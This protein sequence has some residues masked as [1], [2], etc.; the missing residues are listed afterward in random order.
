M[1]HIFATELQVPFRCY[2]KKLTVA[3]CTT[4]LANVQN[5]IFLSCSLGLCFYPGNKNCS[6]QGKMDNMIMN[7]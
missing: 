7:F 5:N 6:V 3:N 2:A 4:G 1:S